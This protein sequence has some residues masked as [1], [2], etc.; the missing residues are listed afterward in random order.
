MRKVYAMAFDGGDG[1]MG[2]ALFDS[3]EACRFAEDVDPET[4]RAE[5]YYKAVWIDDD[6]G[7]VHTLASLREEYEYGDSEIPLG[8]SGPCLLGLPESSS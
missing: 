3:E 4:Y 6:W 8:V 1:S 5:G 7:S 2:V